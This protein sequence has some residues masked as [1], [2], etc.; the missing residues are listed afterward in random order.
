MKLR[1]P[2]LVEAWI[3]FR[4]ETPPAPPD[5]TGATRAERLLQEHFGDE[6]PEVEHLVQDIF[7]F[8]SPRPEKRSE[9]P[10][11]R[12]VV[13]AVRAANSSGTSVV[14]MGPDFA[15]AHFVRADGADY[16]KVSVETGDG[17]GPA[18]ASC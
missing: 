4:F 12:R 13:V 17:V 9:L 15:S 5:P 1:N 8:R 16:W 7:E 18:A 3:D 6:L 11:P 10:V 14:Q 2:P